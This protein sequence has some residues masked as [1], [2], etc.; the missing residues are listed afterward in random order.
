MFS[1]YQGDLP[2]KKNYNLESP[3]TS[4]I[5]NRIH[6]MFANSNRKKNNILNTHHLKFLIT[7]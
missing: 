4:M 1:D 3:K 5:H 6:T 7:N 2:W